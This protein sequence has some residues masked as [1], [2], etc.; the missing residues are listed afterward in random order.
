MMVVVD[1]KVWVVIVCWWL[2]TD[3]SRLGMMV[4]GDMTE[5][6]KSDKVL[7]HAGMSLSLLICV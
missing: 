1:D 2:L 6:S 5:Y 7:C 3:D 4:T